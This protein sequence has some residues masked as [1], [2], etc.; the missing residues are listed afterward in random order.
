MCWQRWVPRSKRAAPVPAQTANHHVGP[1]TDRQL[2]LP[3]VF[4]Y[5]RRDLNEKRREEG[6]RVCF[7][8]TAVM[9][10]E[11]ERE[12]SVVGFS[13]A[14]E[15]SVS[16]LVWTA[17]EGSTYS[18]KLASFITRLIRIAFGFPEGFLKD[19]CRSSLMFKVCFLFACKAHKIIIYYC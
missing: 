5:R 3:A 9:K 10:A 18:E 17:A 19:L 16:W 11:I 7:P 6:G 12:G 4:I 13:Q 1:P 8:E 15:S 2:Q 14:S